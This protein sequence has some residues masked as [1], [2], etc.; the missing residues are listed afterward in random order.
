MNTTAKWVEQGGAQIK[1]FEAVRLFLD[2]AI[3]ANPSFRVT[4]TNLGT[5]CKIT[6]R[7]DGIPL[8]IELAAARARMMSP[9]QLYERLD[10]AFA[11]CRVSGTGVSARH[12]TLRATIDWSYNLLTDSEKLLFRRLGVFYGS[13]S[14]EAAESVS[15]LGLDE[16]FLDVLSSLVDKSLLLAEEHYGQMRYRMLETVRQ[17]A[18]ELLTAS[19]D[20]VPSQ[21]EHL[22]F[23]AQLGAAAK[24]GLRT[25]EQVKWRRSFELD[26]D[27]VR[28]AIDWA[29]EDGDDALT[30]ATIACDVF[31]YWFE[32]GHFSEA[33]AYLERT[34]MSLGQVDDAALRIRILIL[35][36]ACLVYMGDR[37]GLKLLHDGLDLAEASA[38]DLLLFASSWL[39]DCYYLLG[40]DEPASHFFK[41]TLKIAHE[42]GDSKGQGFVLANLAAIA[43]TSGDFAEA[44]TLLEQMLATKAEEQ[45]FKGMGLAHCILGHLAFLQNRTGATE[46][47]KRGIALIGSPP[48]Y[49]LLSGNLAAG[50][51]ILLEKGDP[52][53]AAKVQGFADRV[54]ER[55]GAVPDKLFLQMSAEVKERTRVSL[56]VEAY[57]EAYRSGRTLNLSA[58]L[59]LLGCDLVPATSNPRTPGS[60][61]AVIC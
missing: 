49:F 57:K 61:A 37:E 19:P 13:F 42:T 18:R 48:D 3:Y 10:N 52:E 1:S 32:A 35:S 59:D 38:S 40:E 16:E 47:Y 55:T 4:D 12:Q 41:M 5:I 23:Y 58:A 56:P 15:A 8:A 21:A 51:L 7:L 22:K 54:L 31:P 33:S 53:G 46:H 45:D 26:M 27:N 28:A 6:S 36:G 17:Y 43:C 30:A 14:L 29:L 44:E 50:S 39:G 34:R 25:P 2:R 24:V 60:V 20:L 11:V 9:E